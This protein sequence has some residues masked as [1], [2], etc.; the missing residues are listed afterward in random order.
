[1]QKF[2]QN[3]LMLFLSGL[4]CASCTLPP[5]HESLPLDCGPYPEGYEEIIRGYVAHLLGG[6]EN[7]KDFEIYKKPESIQLDTYY[8]QCALKPLQWVW[9][10]LILYNTKNKEGKYIGKRLHVAW[11]RYD[12]L[13]AYDYDA[14]DMDYFIKIRSDDIKNKIDGK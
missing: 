6:P 10:T 14:V 2:I 3:T 13:V 9:E 1:M 5:P 12:H 11:I 8:P 4:L 7:L